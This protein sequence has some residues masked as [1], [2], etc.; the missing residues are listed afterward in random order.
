MKLHFKSPYLRHIATL[1]SGTALAQAIL[2]LA[3]PFLT[4]L[5]TPDD[6]GLYGIFVAISSVLGMVING[7]F[8]IAILLPK[9]EEEAKSVYSISLITCFILCLVFG[10]IGTLFTLLFFREYLDL[11]VWVFL[12]IFFQGLLQPSQRWLLKENDF[13]KLTISRVAGSLITVGLSVMLAFMG[14]EFKGLVLGKIAGL[15]TE[16]LVS[17]AFHRLGFIHYGF[18]R[19]TFSKYNG[20]L[21]FSSLESLVNNGFKQLPVIVLGSWF[22]EAL[23]GFFT[24]AM[25]AIS[26]PSGMLSQAVGQVF[27]TR[28]AKMAGNDLETFFLKNLRF[29]FL[30]GFIPSLIIVFWGP[31]LFSFVFGAQWSEAGLYAQWLMPFVFVTFLKSPVSSIIDL[32][33]KMHKNLLFELGFLLNTVLSFWIGIVLDD[34]LLGVILFSCFNSILGLIQ[35]WTFYKWSKLK[36]AFQ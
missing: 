31:T 25:N 4:R 14:F 22:N 8:E 29:S 7:R 19:E 6:F 34:G 16:G 12:A 28:A 24:L 21:K 11:L 3:L 20:F 9:E 32:K 5:F 26:R 13:K 33:N 23:A 30:I 1:L 15:V 2:V 10:I 35:L 17:G 18:N 27:F 36:S